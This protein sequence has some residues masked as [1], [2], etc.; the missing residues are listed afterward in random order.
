MFEKTRIT[1]LSRRQYN[2]SREPGSGN[3]V[4]RR[5]PH[6]TFLCSNGCGTNCVLVVI[7][8]T[9][10]GK[11]P[12]L[13][14]CTSRNITRNL[15]NCERHGFCTQDLFHRTFVVHGTYLHITFRVVTLIIVFY[16]ICAVFSSV[17]YVQVLILCESSVRANW[18]VH[19]LLNCYIT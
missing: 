17:I 7:F 6:I 18:Y 12:T 14:F 16:I 1:L 19:Y 2:L 5:I 3:S 15:C 9:S 10:G 11:S 8:H 4:H 13:N